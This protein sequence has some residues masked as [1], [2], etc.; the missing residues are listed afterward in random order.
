[1]NAASAH[2]PLACVMGDIDLVRALG[3]AGIRCAVLA[4][5]GSPALYS[6]FN[7]RDLS[8]ENVSDRV[9]D[10]VESLMRFGAAQPEPPV[11]FYQDDSQ[12]LLVSRHRERLG[13]A[14]RFVIAD[15][16]LVEDVVDKVEFQE[17]ARRLHLPVPAALRVHPA[18]SSPAAIDLHFPVIIKPLFPRDRWATIAGWHKAL[19]IGTPEQLR[20]LWPRLAAAD[21]NL[22]VQEQI[23]GS[24]ARIESYH[25]YVDREETIVGEFTGRKIR[26]YPESCGHSTALEITDAG[27]VAALGRAIVQKLKLRGVAKLDFKRGPDGRLHLLE[28]NPRFNLWHHLGAAAGVNLPALVY[29]D[30]TGLPRPNVARARTGVQWCYFPKDLPAARAGGMP[31]STWLLWVLRCEAKPLLTWDDP[32]PLLRGAW[33]RWF[34]RGGLRRT[35]RR[36]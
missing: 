26:T 22:L 13:Q 16:T 29:A 5:P 30:A 32:M 12:L 33:H 21:L 35:L 1:M 18:G 27:D 10:R 19:P 31:I 6:R 17:L 28:I 20:E 36:T 9:E 25:V 23:P 2:K 8:L 3:L 24:E 15:S 7:R 14:F 4:R 34:S 11:L